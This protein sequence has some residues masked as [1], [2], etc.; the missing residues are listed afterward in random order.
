MHG[1][2]TSMTTYKLGSLLL[3]HFLKENKYWLV[4]Q[5]EQ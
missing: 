1:D 3:L 2:P 4:V 5:S